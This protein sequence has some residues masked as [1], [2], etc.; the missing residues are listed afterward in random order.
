MAEGPAG[1]EPLGHALAAL[2][3]HWVMLAGSAAAGQEERVRR[4]AAVFRSLPGQVSPGPP[5]ARSP[6]GVAVRAIEAGQKTYLTLA[7]DTPYPIRLE[8]VLNAPASATFTDLGRGLNLVPEAVAGG[9]RLVLDLAPFGVAAVRVAA[10]G[11]RVD[12]IRPHHPSAVLANLEARKDDLSRTLTRLNR[13]SRGNGS[14]PPNPGF[15][16]N[17]ELTG[18]RDAHRPNGWHAAGDPTTAVT[19]DPNWPRSGQGSLRLDAAALPAGVVSDAFTPPGGPTLIVRAWVRADRPDVSVRV[20]LEGEPAGRP[21]FVHQAELTA[22]PHWTYVS[23]PMPDIPPDGLERARLRFELPAPGR[24]WL[25]DLAVSGEGLTEPERRN[26]RRTLLAAIQAYREQRF[27]DFAR[28]A[29]S[30][31]ARQAEPPSELDRT[32]LRTGGE[33]SALPATRRLR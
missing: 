7:N 3:A 1:D 24:L 19:I 2:D 21:P 5:A 28:L 29:G 25:D 17:I 9:K 22:Q 33:A 20:R 16:P 31:W 8:T 18:G 15:E 26:A 14:G 23:V 10:P 4:F 30:H 13:M 11:V 6:S 27:A 32:G 12:S